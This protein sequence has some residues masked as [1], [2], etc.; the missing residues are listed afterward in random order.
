M[1]FLKKH[2][3]KILM[4]L[5][6]IPISILVYT[7]EQF[8]GIDGRLRLSLAILLLAI[9]FLFISFGSL[10][11]TN[12]GDFYNKKRVFKINKT[13]FG[14]AEIFRIILATIYIIFTFFASDFAIMGL[15]LDNVITSVAAPSDGV[16][17]RGYSF[18]KMAN[19]ELSSQPAVTR[20]GLVSSDDDLNNNAMLDFAYEQDY[21]LNP[22]TV[23]FDSPFDMINALYDKDVDGILIADNFVAIFEELDRFYNIENET[24]V[25]TDFQIEVQNIEREDIDPTE[26][27]SILLLGLNQ[28]NQALS[29]G[30]INTFMLLTVNLADLTFTITSIPRDSYVW[31]PD[32][33]VNDKLSHTNAGGTQTAIRTIEHLTG[34]DIPYYV[35]LNFTGFMEII[36][37]LGGIYVDVPF[38]IW[39]QDSQRRHGDYMIHIES[40]FQRLNAEQALALTR[41]RNSMNNTEMRGDDFARVEHQQL[42]FQAMLTEMMHSLT[43]VNDILRLLEVVGQ[44]VETNLNS[45]E[46]LSIGQYLLSLLATTS[47]TDLMQDIHFINMVL[48]GHTEIINVRS[49]GALWV[50]FPWSNRVDEARRL[51]EI[52]LGLRAP[53]FNFSFEFDGFS[54]GGRTLGQPRSSFNNVPINMDAANRPDDEDDLEDSPLTEQPVANTPPVNPPPPVEIP[55]YD[56]EEDELDNDYHGDDNNQPDDIPND[57]SNELDNSEDDEPVYGN[58]PPE[59]DEENE[60]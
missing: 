29:S 4:L 48:T 35:K 23:I 39:E 55:P 51:M 57:D 16:T 9:G 3:F 21:F 60:E 19:F 15:R 5:P 41:H 13:S 18:V 37:T 8:S 58:Y 59:E 7:L 2:W 31:V 46:I 26:P 54:H 6:L 22:I 24:R 36:D 53:E 56:P 17:T 52:N 38:E 33:G 25:I 14:I 45:H 30:T 12:K 49:F 20:I 32:W 40:G 42:V 50:S 47:T 10:A 43:S 1:K 27:F 44:H 28:N 11:E 34:I